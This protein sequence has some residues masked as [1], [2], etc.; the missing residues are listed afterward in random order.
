MSYNELFSENTL[1]LVNN[2]GNCK[3]GSIKPPYITISEVDSNI[4]TEKHLLIRF[5]ETEYIN[6][7]LENFIEAQSKKIEEVV[8]A[9][10]KFLS[11]LTHDL[12]G[13][14]SAIICV[15]GILKDSYTEN[16]KKLVP[17]NNIFKC[18]YFYENEHK[19]FFFLIQIE[20][21]VLNKS[22]FH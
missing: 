19:R 5:Q 9:N 21:E 17:G 8:K 3:G 15:L 4:L 20:Q 16:N 7:R 22:I 13:P 2:T 12:R 18:G 14:F 6:T 10:A 11:I 1:N